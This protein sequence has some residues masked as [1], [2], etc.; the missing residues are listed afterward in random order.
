MRLHT[1]T[2]TERDIRQAARFA[3]VRFLRL[4]EKGS[5]SRVRAFIV[6]LAGSS[7]RRTQGNEDYAATWDEWGMF[8]GHL[9]HLDPEMIARGMGRYDN[10]EHFHWSTVGRF[11]LMI[12]LLQHNHRWEYSGSAATGAYWVQQCKS[13]PA[14]FRVLDPKHFKSFTEWKEQSLTLD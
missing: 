7:P 9:F 12:P 3:G 8:F 14:T 11:K 1:D 2:L 13:C 10:A 6:H 4:E 5:K